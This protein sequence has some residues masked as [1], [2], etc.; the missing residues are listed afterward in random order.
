MRT[1]PESRCVG[2]LKGS[3]TMSEPTGWIVVGS[4]GQ[5]A[6]VQIHGEID[7]SNVDEIEK[8]LDDSF[9]DGRMRHV[10]DL[11]QTRYFD[12]TG[13]RLLFSLAARLQARRQELHIVVPEDG[14][15]RRVLEV[16]GVPRI[17]PVHT[18]LADLPSE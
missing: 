14:I 17:V 2:D 10:I 6:V 12:S 4:R 16:T 5:D 8:A 7:I 15:T 18:D 3:S 9:D 13:I 1:A 11:S